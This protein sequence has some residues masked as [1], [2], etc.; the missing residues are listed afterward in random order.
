MLHLYLVNKHEGARFGPKELVLG[1]TIIFTVE[2]QS[3]YDCFVI[4]Q[5]GAP[6]YTEDLRPD[7]D[8]V[9]LNSGDGVI[10]ETNHLLPAFIWAEEGF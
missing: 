8:F 9:R 6:R 10:V 1:Q 5:D 7:G 4:C 3:Q 2:K